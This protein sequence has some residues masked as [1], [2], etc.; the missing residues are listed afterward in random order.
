[1]TRIRAALEGDLDR[2]LR[3]EIGAAETA[4]TAAVKRAAGG[5]QRDLRRQTKRAGLGDGV[6]KAWRRAVYPARGKSIQA[7]GLVFSKATR[8]VEAFA[9]DRVIHARRA[10]WL[11]IPLPAAE[12]QG[13][14]TSRRRSRSSK[15]RRWSELENA[16]ADGR[17][18]TFVQVKATGGL[19]LDTATRPPTPLFLM[20]REVRLSKRLDLDAPQRRWGDRLPGLILREFDSFDRR[21]ARRRAR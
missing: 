20:V 13:L 11:V 9:A 18:L 2:I 19:I 10:R 14:A 3:A 21:Q 1:M 8:I 5:L 17:R 4:V 12:R 15:E 6:E 16:I 7:A